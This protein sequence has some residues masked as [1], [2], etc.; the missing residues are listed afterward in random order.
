MLVRRLHETEELLHQR[1]AERDRLASLQEALACH[2]GS[3][4]I[5]VDMDGHVTSLNEIAE[6]LA[7]TPMADALG[8][9]IGT[10]F[11]PL[12]QTVAGRLQFLQSSTGAQPTQFQHAIDSGRQLTV[13]CSTV[14]LHDTYRNPIGALYVLQDVTALCQL[15]HRLENEG[16]LPTAEEIIASVDDEDHAREG[17]IGTSPAMVRVRAFIDRAARSDATLLVTGES[18]T[19][20]ELVARA[21]HARS[22]RHERTFV[23]V[24]C[25]AIPE[26]LIESELFGHVRGA[27]TGAVSD[28]AG[29]FRL[30]DGGTIFLDEIGELPLSLQ[31]KLLRVLQERTFTPV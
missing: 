17:L 12:R 22:V 8:K 7:G 31:V 5:T 19:G 15:E 25:G 1:E 29:L 30:A 26:N 23:P 2:I 10:I 24:N 28:R 27:F 21:V 20:K 14:V 3:A 13:R 16:M 6:Q 11:A 4:L 18:G 9:D